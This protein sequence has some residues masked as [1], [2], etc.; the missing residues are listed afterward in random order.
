M[1]FYFPPPFFRPICLPSILIMSARVIS[2]VATMTTELKMLLDTHKVREEI[3]HFL[4]SEDVQC[5]TV[6]QFAVI[7]TKEDEL[8]KDLLE[9]ASLDKIKIGDKIAVR[10]AWHACRATLN[11]S[12]EKTKSISVA[13]SKMPD[14]A[15]SRLR[16]ARKDLHRFNLSGAWL[17]NE[18]VMTKFYKD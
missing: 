10:G 6:S 1:R 8:V 13:V 11:G 18:E 7:V 9:E 17:T 12:A 5:T 14:G 4:L 2:P 15:E 16:D 3:Q